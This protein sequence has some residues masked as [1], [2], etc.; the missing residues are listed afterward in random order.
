MTDAAQRP[1]LAQ[2][3][4][5]A[6]PTEPSE[7]AR[8][9][10]LIQLGPAPRPADGADLAVR[11]RTALAQEAGD[12]VIGLERASITAVLDGADVAAADLDLSGVVAPLQGAGAGGAAVGGASAAQ[13]WDPE[14]VRREPATLR[15]L[16][17]DAHPLVA[18]DLPVDLTAELE[19]LR[20]DWVEGSDGRVGIAPVEPTAAHPVSGHA[21]VAVDK[22]GLVATVRGVL[23]V[24]LLQQGITLTGLDLE[25]VSQGPR[26]ATL[27]VDAAIKKGMF[28][29]ARVQ[30]TAS[31]SID[32]NLVLAVRDVRLA[33]GNPLVS[34]LLGTVKGRIDAATSRDID[35]A[36]QLPDGV[37]V[38]D[39][40]LEVGHEIVASARLA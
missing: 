32:E 9:P 23:S 17:V 33:S 39:V 25:V 11:I 3:A 1:D 7:S 2:P 30:A 37:R 18:V 27:W 13:R 21:R 20:F 35:L 4:E 34:A 16:R 10:G 12:Q 40:R 29:S 19:G 14:I 6:Q 28:L 26:S 22:A 15:R 38:A 36:E 5:P 31:V 8:T 24:V